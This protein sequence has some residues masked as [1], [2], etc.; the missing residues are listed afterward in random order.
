[1]KLKAMVISTW[2]NSKLF[3]MNENWN[4]AVNTQLAITNR[5][6]PYFRDGSIVAS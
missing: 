3:S 4:L 6:L 2:L 5:G 1:M